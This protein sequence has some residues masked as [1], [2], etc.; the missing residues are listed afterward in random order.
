MN[1]AGLADDMPLELFWDKCLS[2]LETHHKPENE[3]VSGK[4]AGKDTSRQDPEIKKMLAQIESN[5][6][7]VMKDVSDIKQ[8]L[9]S[10]KKPLTPPEPREIPHDFESWLK[11]T[12]GS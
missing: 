8:F 11:K 7:T 3:T 2:F 4:D 12:H 5:L 10:R 9:T 1:K 6:F